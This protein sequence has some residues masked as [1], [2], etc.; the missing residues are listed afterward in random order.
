[1]AGKQSAAMIK[2]QKLITEKGYEAPAAAKAAGVALNSIYV[3]RWW[4]DLQA[5]RAQKEQA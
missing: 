2:A 1:M 3:K 5:L 4:K